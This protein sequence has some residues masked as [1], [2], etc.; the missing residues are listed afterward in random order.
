MGKDPDQLNT[1]FEIIRSVCPEVGI[2]GGKILSAQVTDPAA[3]SKVLEKI[4]AIGLTVA[5]STCPVTHQFLP[6]IYIRG[7]TISAGT[8]ALGFG[9]KEPCFNVV[10]EGRGMIVLNGE[11]KEVVAPC[12]MVSEPGEQKIGLIT[13]TM[14]W[15]T[16]HPTNETD[17]E[18]LEDLL[19]IKSEAYIRWK[20]AINPE[21]IAT[22]HASYLGVIEEAGFTPEQV[23]AITRITSD[24][25]DAP[26]EEIGNVYF[27]PSPIDGIGTFA[28]KVFQPGE[29]IGSARIAGKRTPIGRLCN[30][31]ARPNTEARRTNQGDI[32]F[33]ATDVIHIG[34]EV[35]LDYRQTRQVSQFQNP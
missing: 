17:L 25:I 35:T 27:V 26:A 20:A 23:L 3:W 12:T 30:H 13:E 16:V 28:A 24:N 22:D 21:K 34:V 32:A 6:G 18:K 4:E 33:F 8:F 10:L 11:L 7:V 31:S 15:L 14:R 1:P 29:F 5:P 9:H 19:L 2:F